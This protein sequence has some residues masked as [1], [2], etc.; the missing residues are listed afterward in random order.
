MGTIAGV[1]TKFVADF[2]GKKDEASVNLFFYYLLKK[3]SPITFS[4]G[5]ILIIFS[6][7]LASIF[8]AHSVA[9]IVLGVSMMIN[10]Y[11]TI[12]GSY[13][14]A[15]Q[16]FVLQ[17]MLGFL[18]VIVTI[19]LSILFINLGFGATGAVIGQLFAGILVTV[20]TFLNIKKSIYP[21]QEVQKQPTF[22]LSGFT[23]WSFIYALGT[24]SL[25]STDILMVRAL[26]DTHTSGLYSALSILGRMILFG[27]TPLI[28]LMLPLAAHRHSATGTAQ[29]IL[30]KLGAVISL[31][32]F[33]G[34]GI[35]SLF[36]TFIIRILSGSEY[37]S[38]APLLPVFAFS[39]MFFGLSQ[40]LLSY[41]MATGRPK[42]NILLLVVTILQ[43]A[44][45]YFSRFSISSTIWSQSYLFFGL[46]CSL[47]I[48]TI[49]SV[50]QKR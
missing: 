20:I 23:G 35:F 48:Y 22:S 47:L 38:A 37:I 7:P 10:L 45:I 11:Q 31:L 36:P 9:F 42:A 46:F 4:L 24:M 30:F 6:G 41:L 49:S 1:A 3:I 32:G 50:R 5:F 18:S 28:G 8:K 34:A 44:V 33:I 29:T 16:K 25:M 27:L 43:P 12:I 21:K 39:M 40:F 2:R 26:F 19:L 13:L 17:T 14:V 15:F